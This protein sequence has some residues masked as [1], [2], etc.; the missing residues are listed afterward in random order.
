MS[1]IREGPIATMARLFERRL[2]R[3]LAGAERATVGERLERLGQD[4]LDDVRAEGRA[5]PLPVASAPR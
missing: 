2:G 1:T 5:N 3:P 4:R